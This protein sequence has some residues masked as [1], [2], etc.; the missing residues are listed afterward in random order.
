[1]KGVSWTT[2]CVGRT[3]W[4]CFNT[5]PFS[6]HNSVQCWRISRLFVG[7]NIKCN[8][9][10]VHHTNSISNIRRVYSLTTT[11]REEKKM[12]KRMVIIIWLCSSTHLLN[13]LCDW[14]ALNKQC[15]ESTLFDMF[16]AHEESHIY[17][18]IRRAHIVHQAIALFKAHFLS[19]V[20][21]EW[22]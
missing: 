1:M 2:Q 12:K 16:T 8:T 15:N 19:M 6:I 21:R 14:A 18:Y 5:S 17:Y 7:C 22:K 9:C 3:C 20:K 4:Q 13:Y 11:S 10:T